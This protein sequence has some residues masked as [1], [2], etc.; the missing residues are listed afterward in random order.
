MYTNKRVGVHRKQ[1]KAAHI[2][3][4]LL[5]LL[6]LCFVGTSLFSGTPVRTACAGGTTR[7]AGPDLVVDMVYFDDDRPSDGDWIEIYVVVENRGDEDVNASFEMKIWAD[8]DIDIKTLEI[9]GLEA[10]S[11]FTISTVWTT[12]FKFYGEGD[13][14]IHVQLDPGNEIA[15][16][17]E[18]N[19]DHTQVLYFK[20][21]WDRNNPRPLLLPAYVFAGLLFF[22]VLV[23][24]PYREYCCRPG[25]QGFRGFIIYWKNDCIE[26]IKRKLGRLE[27]QVEDQLEEMGK[28]KD[29]EKGGG[30]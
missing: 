10:G 8:D 5:Y 1:G 23:D 25:S 15:E 2:P 4:L 6:V 12:M 16:S 20:H 17:D 29:K 7:A 28:E 27:D 26:W 13:H 30:S 22:A 19:N 18:S 21:W 14:D 9:Q 11:K 24:H 3:V